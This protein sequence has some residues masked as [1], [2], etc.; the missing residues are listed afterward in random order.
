MSKKMIIK[1][2]VLACI[3]FVDSNCVA[4]TMQLVEPRCE[5]HVDPLGIDV[6]Q[7]R[8]GWRLESDQRA[9]LQSAYRILVAGSPEMLANDVGDLWDTGKV[10]SD[11]SIQIAY[12]GKPLTSRQR[13]HWK[14]MV[15]DQDGK[16]SGWSEPA[17][18]SMG[19]LKLEDWKAQWIGYDAIPKD[20]VKEGPKV[21]M[22]KA[23]YGVNGNRSKQA[24]VTEKLREQ[25]AAGNLK[26]EVGNELVEKDPAPGKRKKLELEYT[27][28]GV[29]RKRIFSEG[30]TFEF[31]SKK[32]PNLMNRRYL[33]SPYLRKE[34][35]VK[36][37]VKRAVVLRFRAGGG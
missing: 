2:A 26:F 1:A 30:E 15:W 6:L 22:V 21:V 20:P 34:F 9:Q 7:P 5:Y 36:S 28:D 18:W 3:V 32:R 17:L 29:T 24:D 37:P 14:V 33:P 35:A 10:R 16:A 25:V 4:A 8:L 31:F 13:C 11:E 27:F 23:L 19:L 12:Q